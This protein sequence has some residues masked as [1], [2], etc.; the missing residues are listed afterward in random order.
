MRNNYVLGFD[1]NSIRDFAIYIG[2]VSTARGIPYIE[3]DW[4]FFSQYIFCY[5]NL[6]EVKAIAYHAL[7]W[8]MQH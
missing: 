6:W 4:L 2:M 5:S 3:I 8:K 1:A 7:F